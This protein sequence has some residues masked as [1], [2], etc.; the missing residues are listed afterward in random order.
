MV[1]FF[2]YGGCGGCGHRT[3]AAGRVFW[4]VN[5]KPATGAKVCAQH[6]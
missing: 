5:C 3:T 6:F 4:E 1:L 2:L